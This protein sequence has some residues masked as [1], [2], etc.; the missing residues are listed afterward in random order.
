[1]HYLPLTIVVVAVIVVPPVPALPAE[2]AFYLPGRLRV[3]KKQS[4]LAAA[5]RAKVQFLIIVCI[6][7]LIA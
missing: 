5:D 2:V 3:V 1:M 4:E 7:F 6:L